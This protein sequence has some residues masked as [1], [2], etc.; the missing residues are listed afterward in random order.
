MK[1][2]TNLFVI[3]LIDIVDLFRLALDGFAAFP[4]STNQRAPF[5]KERFQH[6]F[7]VGH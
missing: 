3:D 2:V 5:G 4:L 1:M 7:Q 6:R